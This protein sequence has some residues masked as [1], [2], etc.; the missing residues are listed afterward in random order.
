[1]EQ[2]NPIEVTKR[3]KSRRQALINEFASYEPIHRDIRDFIG[4]R[5]ARFRGEPVNRG[6]RQDEKIINSTPRYAL[7]TLTGGMQS[8][9]TSPLRPWFKLASPDPELN[10]FEPVKFWLSDVERRM[11]EVF[12]KSNFYNTLKIGA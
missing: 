7:R 10:E 4:P 12:S 2:F 5:T 11:R 1:M 9:I 8:G 3:Y 6:D